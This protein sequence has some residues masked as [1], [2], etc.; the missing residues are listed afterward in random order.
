MA[1]LKNIS[2]HDIAGLACVHY[3][4]GEKG[5]QE[6]SLSFIHECGYQSFSSSTT[7]NDV[8]PCYGSIQLLH[9]KVKQSWFNP[10][11]LQ[12]GPSVERILKRGLTVIPKLTELTAKATVT[13]YERLHQ[14]LAIYLIPIMPFNSICLANNYKGL[15]PPGLGTEAYA[16][17]STAVLELLPRLLPDTDLELHA[18][19]SAVRNSSRNGYDLL[20]RIL[21]LY[22]PGFDPR[23]PIAQPIWSHDTN[24]LDFS[25]SHLLYFRLQAK[26]HVYFTPRDSTNIFLC[27]IAPSEYSTAVTTLQTSVNAYRHPDDEDDLPDNLRVDGIAMSIHLNAKHNVRDLALPRIN[28]TATSSLT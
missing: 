5:V 10:R 24:I 12:S 19:I 17:C 27:A 4:G 15:F 7:A 25:E 6:L 13:F 22:V 18:T 20:W 21:A 28:H 2:R 23:V 11:T 9:K 8:L 26:K 3:H 1:R 16:E 14:V